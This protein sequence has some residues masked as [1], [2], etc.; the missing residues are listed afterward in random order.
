MTFYVFLSC[1]T[2]F[3]VHCYYTKTSWSLAVHC[4]QHCWRKI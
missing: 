2:R 1:L 4:T 3:L